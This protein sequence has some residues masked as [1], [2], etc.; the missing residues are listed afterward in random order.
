MTDGPLVLIGGQVCVPGR[1]GGPPLPLPGFGGGGLPPDIIE[2]WRHWWPLQTRPRTSQPPIGGDKP[3]ALWGA[4]PLR[5]GVVLNLVDAPG[6]VFLS[7]GMTVST[8][9]FK[10]AAGALVVYGPDCPQE[11]Y[12]YSA[13]GSFLAYVL[14]T[15]RLDDSADD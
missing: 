10:V 3:V 7:E 15:L 11:L 5:V 8:K 2:R 1:N 12:G 4:E 13:S 14:E 6:D 9:G